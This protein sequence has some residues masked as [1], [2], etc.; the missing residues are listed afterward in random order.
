[1]DTKPFPDLK[2]EDRPDLAQVRLVEAEVARG[3]EDPDF[4]QECIALELERI[5]TWSGAPG[6][7]PF[8]VI[9]GSGV[10]CSFGYFLPGMATGAHEHTDW[11]VT[12]VGLNTLQ[13]RTFDR[14][15]A[16][17]QNRLVEAKAISATSGLVGHIYDPCIHDTGNVTRSPTLTMHFQSPHDGERPRDPN[18][19]F[20]GRWTIARRTT[21]VTRGAIYDALAS[22]RR[23]M[24]L[25]ILAAFADARAGHWTAALV[26]TIAARGS[27]RTQRA[28]GR[29]AS[30]GV[31]AC[32]WDSATLSLR[33][34]LPGLETFLHDSQ[35]ELAAIDENG[36]QPLLRCD[37]WAKPILDRIL[38]SRTFVPKDLSSAVTVA[39]L[40]LLIEELDEWALFDWQENVA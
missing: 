1:L 6:L 31:R 15:I 11:V 21:A 8:A 9:P 34:D 17:S 10:R 22:R 16:Y 18:I 40:S 39:D 37:A 4:I 23:Q 29:M 13:V 26:K 7:R 14:A 28:C 12:A 24:F 20:D 33:D 38:D 30:P 2:S 25:R 36:R 32:A 3:L 27:L 19:P 5:D 35:V